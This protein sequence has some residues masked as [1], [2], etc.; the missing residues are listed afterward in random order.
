MEKFPFFQWYA[1]DAEMDS[2]YRMLTWEER[3]VFHTLLNLAWM[4]D[5]L[6]S[7][8]GGIARLLREPAEFVARIWTSL[9]PM[10]HVG[11][12]GLMRNRRQEIQRAEIHQAQKNASESGKRG[13]KA[14][15]EKAAAEKLKEGKPKPPLSDP[16]RVAEATLKRPLSDPSTRAYESESEDLKKLPSE[17]DWEVFASLYPKN[18]FDENLAAQYF[19]EHDAAK[20]IA[21]LRRAVSSE[22]WR[23]DG[24]RYVPKA[25]NFIRD[26]QYAGFHPVSEIASVNPEIEATRRM[27]REEREREAS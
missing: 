4:N 9:E 16:T 10:F 1:A 14:K 12:D 15:A 8:I 21:G 19:I 17:A 22:D 25:S 18:R 24:G 11:D 3:G 6:P 23:K 27:L 7:D 20:V 26:G 13:A 5:G 2:R